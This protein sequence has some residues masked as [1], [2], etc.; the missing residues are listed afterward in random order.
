[1]YA[2]RLEGAELLWPADRCPFVA[3]GSTCVRWDG[4]VSPCLPLLHTHESYL[5]NRLRTVTAHTMGSVEEQSLQEIW[6]SPE[7]VGLRQRLEDFDFSPCT[8]CNSCEKADGNQEDCFGNTTPACG[9]CLW[10]QGFIQCP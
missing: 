6:M 3:R 1:M 9:G 8:A 2:P 10:A 4:A 5:E 7:Y